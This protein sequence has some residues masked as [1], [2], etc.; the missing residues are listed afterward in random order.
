M[1]FYPD[2][3]FGRTKLV[4]DDRYH[5]GRVLTDRRITRRE[6]SRF[7][8]R[9]YKPVLRLPEFCP[10]REDFVLYQRLAHLLVCI[11]QRFAAVQNAAAVNAFDR[12]SGGYLMCPFFIACGIENDEESQK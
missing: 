9:N 8:K 10:L 4:R 3:R 5:S 6:K 2:L 7:R 12:E 1:S 11:L